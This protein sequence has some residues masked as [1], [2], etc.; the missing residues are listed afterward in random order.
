M[1]KRNRQPIR[2]RAAVGV[3][4][5]GTNLPA[6]LVDENGRILARRHC[7]TPGGGVAIAAAMAELVND[8]VAL[9]PSPVVG[10]GLGTP[11]TLGR[12]GRIA[13]GCFNLPGWNGFPVRAALKRLTGLPLAGDN[14]VNVATLGEWQFGGG[15]GMSDLVMLTLGTGVG[16][17]V[18]VNHTLLRGA[19]GSGAELGHLTI[20]RGGRRCTCGGRG[21][22]EAYLSAA[23]IVRTWR[24]QGGRGAATP[25]DVF[26]RARRGERAAQRTV[27]L[28]AAQLG[29][30]LGNLITIFNPAG[31]FIGGGIAGAARQFL[32]AARRAAQA[33]AWCASW[34]AVRIAPAGPDAGLTGAAAL[35]FQAAAR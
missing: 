30:L 5:G 18:I 20:E 26:A 12:D 21:C 14:D 35:A 6:A 32:P 8:L 11:G 23:G 4:L 28:A 27:A 15:R 24:E 13:G 17:G 16:G 2:C 19:S 29:F 1:N 22:V 10:I 9:S 25:K 7:P 34:P 33:Q 3:D 31:I